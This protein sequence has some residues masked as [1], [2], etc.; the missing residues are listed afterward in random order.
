MTYLVYSSVIDGNLSVIDGCLSVIDGSVSAIDGLRQKLST[1]PQD[2][3]FMD[4][5]FVFGSS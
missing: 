2:G 1:Y 4:I 5:L 3:N